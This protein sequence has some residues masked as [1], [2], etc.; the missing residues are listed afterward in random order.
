M[1]DKQFTTKLKS[2]LSHNNIDRRYEREKTGLIASKRI[3]K[4]GTTDRIF[5]RRDEKK[6]DRNYVVSIVLDASGSMEQ[7]IG[8]RGITRY[9]VAIDC[10]IRLAESLEKVKGV[11]YEVVTFSGTDLVLKSFD[12][13]LD[14]E[15]LKSSYLYLF[16]QRNLYVDFLINKRTGDLFDYFGDSK[17]LFPGY[18]SLEQETFLAQNYDCVAIAR[19]E[20]RLQEQSGKKIILTFSDGSPTSCA[21]YR[22]ANQSGVKTLRGD[23]YTKKLI[24]ERSPHDALRKVVSNIR[25]RKEITLIGIGIDTNVVRHFYSLWAEVDR[26]EDFFPTTVRLLSR[27]FKKV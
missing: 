1:N 10:V 18:V 7:P 23:Y 2:I 24:G 22:L 4:Y 21:G 11:K 17:D 20:K 27:V 16:K 15:D 26:V 13:P 6:L 25:K 12:D 14:S 8:G 9:S 5:S 19:A 3:G